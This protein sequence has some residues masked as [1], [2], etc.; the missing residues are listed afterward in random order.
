MKILI[1]N[2]AFYPDVVSSAQHAGDLAASLVKA[3][4]QVTVLADSRAYDE[5]GRRFQSRETWRGVRIIR[6]SS[7]GFGKTARWRRAVDFASL[8]LSCALRLMFLPRFD[9]VIAMT[10]PPLIS[11]LAALMVPLKARKL[12]FW[13][14]DLNPDEAIAAG[15]LRPESATARLLSRLMLY[16]MRRAESI[17]AMDRFMQERIRAKGVAAEKVG[18]VPPWA[19]D[20]CVRFD[21]DARQR[22][23]ARHGL[24]ERFVVMYSGNHSPCH[25]LDTLLA[26]AERLAD[27]PEI[28]FLFVGGG[29]EFREP[30]AL[31]QRGAPNI[32]CLPYQPQ[33]ELAGSLSAGDLHVVVM[34]GAFVGIVHPCKVYNILAVGAPFIY[35]GPKESH[36]TDLV[37]DLQGGRSVL[38]TGHG[39]VEG[40]VREIL[41]AAQHP[42]DRSYAREF[43]SRFSRQVLVPQIIR[44]LET[45]A[46]E[47][48]GTAAAASVSQPRHSP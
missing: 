14:M 17:V 16:S 30:L 43:T 11:F 42:A 2:Q 28:V 24:S 33:A 12:L 40:V 18:V 39:D 6:A 31:E 21:A 19:H 47:F 3:G 5:R 8:M 10:S 27:H 25:P 13:S 23:R 7:T 34:G 20:D 15:W 37:A 32:R 4:H 46:A 48:S 45:M 22:F 41:E 36:I 9:V 38:V 44:T 29:S 26:A 35:I 1:L